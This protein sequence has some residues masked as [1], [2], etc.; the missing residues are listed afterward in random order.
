MFSAWVDKTLPDV[1][2]LKFKF[3]LF[4]ALSFTTY[5]RYTIYNINSNNNNNIYIQGNV[6]KNSRERLSM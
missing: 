6:H 2:R 1:D 5:Q 4:I 3:K